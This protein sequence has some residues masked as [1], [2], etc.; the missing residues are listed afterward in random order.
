MRGFFRHSRGRLTD[1][2]VSVLWWLTIAYN[3]VDMVIMWAI[4]AQS[5]NMAF[6]YLGLWPLLVVVFSAM[7]LASESRKGRQLSYD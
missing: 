4:A 3:L 5:E 1:T 7:A 6:Y 2:D